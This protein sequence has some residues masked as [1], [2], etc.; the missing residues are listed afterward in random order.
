MKSK[1]IKKKQTAVKDSLIHLNIMHL[2]NFFK[3]LRRIKNF[4]HVI[5]CRLSSLTCH[6]MSVITTSHLP[7]LLRAS[8][9]STYP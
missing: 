1:I 4:G 3:W 5:I 2:N 8:Y 6:Y 7:Q 9:E